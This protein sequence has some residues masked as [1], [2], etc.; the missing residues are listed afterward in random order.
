MTSAARVRD[1]CSTCASV[2]IVLPDIAVPK[3]R[4]HRRHLHLQREHEG[5]ARVAPVMEPDC[6]QRGGLH[7]L[8]GRHAHDAGVERRPAGP[9]HVCAKDIDFL[10]DPHGP[11]PWPTGTSRGPAA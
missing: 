4:L 2:P 1:D 6:R 7:E 5:G 11:P 9:V 3:T 8:A 10:T